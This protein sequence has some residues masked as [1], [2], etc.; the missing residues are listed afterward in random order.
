MRLQLL[1]VRVVEGTLHLPPG[2]AIV[3]KLAVI[4]GKLLKGVAV[5]ATQ[6]LRIVSKLVCS[7]FKFSVGIELFGMKTTS[8]GKPDKKNHF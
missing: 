8:H 6:C 3:K 5:A 7:K 2:I 1:L 4:F